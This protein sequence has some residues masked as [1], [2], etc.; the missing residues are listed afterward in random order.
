MAAVS[1]QLPD[2]V[3]A[4]VALKPVVV[5]LGD[6]LGLPRAEPQR[7]EVHETWPQLVRSALA[8]ATVHQ[9]SQ[10]GATSDDLLAQF[11]YLSGLDIRLLI[12]QSG[13]VDCAPR[14]LR[15][16]E[17]LALRMLGLGPLLRS[18]A[19]RRC[20]RWLR[21]RRNIT[22]LPVQQFMANALRLRDRARCRLLW[23]QIV[24]ASG[25]EQQVPGVGASIA[26]FNRHLA[27]S[28]GEAFV[29]L[30][31]IGDGELMSDGHH[32]NAAGHRRVFEALMQKGIGETR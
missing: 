2:A 29:P 18:G 8:D 7:V 12:V 23:L 21:S 24:G 30:A 5:I 10:G 25:Y 16:R 6:S 32:L 27:Q 28:L 22:Y 13:I 19:G 4:R 26:E 31:A 9:V 15:Q 14:A 20:L 17:Q 11:E 3:G 1:A